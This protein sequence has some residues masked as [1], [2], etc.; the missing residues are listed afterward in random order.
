MVDTPTHIKG[1]ILDYVIT[2]IA[3]MV[4]N[5]SIES[6]NL[7]CGSDHFRIKFNLSM[8]IAKNKP[9]KRSIYNFKRANWDALNSDF[10]NVNWPSFLSCN[11]IEDSLVKFESKFFSICNKHIPKIKI[12]NE[13][14]PPWYDSEVYELD[15]K[16]KSPSQQV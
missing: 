10:S 12:S 14:K 4:K 5:L 16:K 15:R 8:N 2:D 13:F 11:N 9:L 3:H 6:D 7:I 1:N